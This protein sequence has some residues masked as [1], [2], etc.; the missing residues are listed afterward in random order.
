MSGFI[1][2]LHIDPDYQITYF[3]LRS[4]KSIRTSVPL[5]EAIELLKKED[6]DL[7]VS[8]PHN[9]VIMK[10][11]DN[12]SNPDPSST[13]NNSLWRATMTI[14]GKYSPIYFLKIGKR[15]PARFQ[16]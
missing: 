8:E 5:Q 2:I 9:R 10:E 4:P 14:S 13:T 15:E 6:F 3:I 11:Q 16:I 1:K 7:I 12:S